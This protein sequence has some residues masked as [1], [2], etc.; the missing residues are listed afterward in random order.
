MA[1]EFERGFQA[2]VAGRRLASVALSPENLGVPPVV[3]QNLFQVH[4]ATWCGVISRASALVVAAT[5][6]N[7]PITQRR[8]RMIFTSLSSPCS[9]TTACLAKDPPAPAMHQ[10]ASAQKK[11]IVHIPIGSMSPVTLKKIRVV[12]LLAGRDKRAVAKDYIW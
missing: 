6:S 5:A 4:A 12:H 7:A 8:Y 9:G 1:D 11:R 3:G 10:Y 2:A